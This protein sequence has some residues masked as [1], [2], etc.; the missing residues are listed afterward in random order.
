MDLYYDLLKHPVFS[1][2][3][4]QPYYNTKESARTALKR[5]M[6]RGL[7][8]KIRTEKNCA[9]RSDRGLRDWHR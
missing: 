2:D 9:I 6:A 4:V 7:V 5:L 8:T 1:I 3:T